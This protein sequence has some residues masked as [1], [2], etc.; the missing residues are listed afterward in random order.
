MEREKCGL[1]QSEKGIVCE[2]RDPGLAYKSQPN[3]NCASLLKNKRKQEA[4]ID[5]K[6]FE[7]LKHAT[8]LDRLEE[9]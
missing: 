1:L 5:L 9:R 7:R 8:S 4:L 2:D 6:I 3:I